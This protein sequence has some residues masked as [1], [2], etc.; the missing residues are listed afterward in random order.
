VNWSN[1]H[2]QIRNGIW[3][4]AIRLICGSIGQTRIDTLGAMIGQTQRN[5]AKGHLR[6][7]SGMCAEEAY[8]NTERGRMNT[9]NSATQFK[10]TQAP[11]AFA[12]CRGEGVCNVS[13]IDAGGVH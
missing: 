13:F 8:R 3:S 12:H 10:G 5:L 7:S 4:G 11:S 1:A 2:R 9:A 6:E